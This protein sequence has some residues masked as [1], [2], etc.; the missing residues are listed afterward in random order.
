MQTLTIRQ[1]K[2]FQANI[3]KN[4]IYTPVMYWGP[5]GVGK[6]SMLRSVAADHDLGYE[7]IRLGQH[8][9]L[10]LLG[11]PAGQTHNFGTEENPVF[12]Q[13]TRYAR[14]VMFPRTS[15]HLINW[16]EI[17][18]APPTMVGLMQQVLLDRRMGDYVLP[19]NTFQ[20]A[21][22]NDKSDGAAVF[23]MPATVNNRLIHVSVM[24]TVEEWI[25]HALRHGF[26]EQIIS[27]IKFKS[28]YLHKYER[29]EK[30]WPSPR[31]WETAS[32]L[33]S[34]GM[35][36]EGSVGTPIAA[37]FRSF[38]TLLNEM[39]NAQSVLDGENVK[40]PVKMELKYALITS[41][42]VRT[43]SGIHLDNGCKWLDSHPEQLALYINLLMQRLGK[44]E[45]FTN[46]I[47]DAT[48]NGS[49]VALKAM[50]QANMVANTR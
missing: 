38:Q 6:S 34:A 40:M 48:A 5:S 7:D 27:F 28:E 44:T 41:M 35:D 33:V 26:N 13:A 42:A 45:K 20:T 47:K 8:T 36:I 15:G 16:D 19:D 50:R 22:G 2:E 11:L 46:I 49:T 4:K 10:T 32:R 31:S 29:T 9:P 43:E 1:A 25:A 21:A 12:D 30:A 39:P 23:E 18:M 3:I 14:P 17:N 37:E 24:H